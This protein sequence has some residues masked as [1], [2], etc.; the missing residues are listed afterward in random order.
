MLGVTRLVSVGVAELLWNSP[1]PNMFELLLASAR[2]VGMYD[3]LLGLIT[4]R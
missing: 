4:R 2:S 1:R 3:L